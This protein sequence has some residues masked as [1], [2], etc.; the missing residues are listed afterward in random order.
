MSTWLS[1]AQPFPV[2]YNTPQ[3]GMQSPILGVVLHTT[4]H[5]AGDETISRFQSD[6]QA[7]QAQSAHFVIDRTGQ[8]GQ[9]RSLSDVAW[10]IRGNST[11]YIG[12]EH[13]AKLDTSLTDDQVDASAELLAALNS[14]LSIPLQAIA[15]PGD[16]GIGIHVNFSKT[17]CGRNVFWLGSDKQVAQFQDILDLATQYADT[18]VVDSSVRDS[19]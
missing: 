9:C 7:L 1:I 14:I 12:V 10:H 6:W 2:T 4:N 11:R 19:P 15:S 5:S 8:L 13:I 18:S 3:K 16:S 17:N